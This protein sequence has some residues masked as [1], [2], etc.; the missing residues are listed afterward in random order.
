MRGKCDVQ[1]IGSEV[2]IKSWR[3][4]VRSRFSDQGSEVRS[5]IKRFQEQRSESRNNRVE[6]EKQK[7]FDQRV[8][9]DY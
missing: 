9:F 2:R 7:Y 6:Y 8:L 4:G 3:V 1:R 5:E